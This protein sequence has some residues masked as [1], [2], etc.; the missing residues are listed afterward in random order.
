M[1]RRVLLTGGAGYIGSHTYV[2]L[3]E[4][5]YEVLILDNFANA[6][7]TVPE[8]LERIT[9]RPVTIVEGDIRDGAALAR[10]F[11]DHVV[12]AVVH[13]AALKAVGES[14][15]RPLDYFDVN[16]GGLTALLRAMDGAGC[17]RLVFSSSATVYGV[18]DETPTPGNRS[19]SGD[20]PYAA[21]PKIH[22]RSRCWSWLAQPAIPSWAHRR[23]CAISTRR[24]R[25]S[26][27]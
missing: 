24:A 6:R 10:V 8:R 27:P 20:E 26:R 5:G 22:G 15:A 3:V 9:G 12:D 16:V 14:M 11:G 2:A 17:R 21:E 4:A 13:F 7:R 19:V 1:T 25:I 23:R 18:P